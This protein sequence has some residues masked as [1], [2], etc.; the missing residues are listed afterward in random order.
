MILSIYAHCDTKN[1]IDHLLNFVSHTKCK[2]IRNGTEHTGKEAKEHINKKYHY[3]KEKIKTTEDFIKYSA[4]KSEL[5]GKRY[6]VSCPNQKLQYSNIWLL[7]ELNN[8][9]DQTQ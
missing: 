1:E 6:R 3:Y 8:Y 4:T 9:R 2:Y 5:S 7:N